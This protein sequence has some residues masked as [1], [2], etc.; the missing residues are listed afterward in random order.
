MI[1]LLTLLPLVGGAGGSATTKL[2]DIA[3]MIAMTFAV[4]CLAMAGLLWWGLSPANPGM[5]FEEIR[6]WVPALGISYHV[7]VDGLGA[8]MLVLSAIVV[9]MSLMASWNNEKHGP[10][11]CALVLFLEAGLFGTFTALNFRALVHLLGAEPDSGILPGADLG[12]PAT[13]QGGGRVL[14]VHDGGQRGAAAGVPG[15]F[16]GDRDNSILC[17]WRRWDSRGN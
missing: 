4:G 12:Q 2:G 17:G 13:R 11:Y 10:V 3:R 5:Q 14:P 1:T 7:G 16:P 9:L 15:D 8:L 6:P